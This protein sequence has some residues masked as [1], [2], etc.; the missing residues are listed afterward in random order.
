MNARPAPRP[1]DS[2][3]SCMTRPLRYTRVQGCG[4]SR[5]ATFQPQPPLLKKLNAPAKV[6]IGVEAHDPV[7]TAKCGRSLTAWI[8][9]LRRCANGKAETQPEGNR[10]EASDDRRADGR[11]HAR[12]RNHP[13][14]RRAAG[15]L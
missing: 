2:S 12:G 7:L 1:R 8:V 14:G 6:P 13:L 9:R 4:V 15:R 3:V 11:R 5:V 10:P